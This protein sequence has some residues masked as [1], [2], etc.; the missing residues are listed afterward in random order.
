MRFVKETAK[1]KFKRTRFLYFD[2]DHIKVV[3]AAGIERILSGFDIPFGTKGVG[4]NFLQWIGDDKKEWRL[5]KNLK[6]LV[7]LA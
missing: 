1:R 5:S 2:R 7:R 3:E 4:K 6:R